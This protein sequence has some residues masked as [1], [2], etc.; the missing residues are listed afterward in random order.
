MY[1]W[2]ALMKKSVFYKE[3][4]LLFLVISALTAIPV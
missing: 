1:L 3:D 2:I 4:S